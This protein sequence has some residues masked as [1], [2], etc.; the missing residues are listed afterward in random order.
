MAIYNF[1]QQVYSLSLTANVSFNK[2]FAT[3]EALQDYVSNTIKDLL[4]DS[5]TQ[6]VIGNWSVIW[7]PYTWSKNAAKD[8]LK[9]TSSKPYYSD[10]T[11]YLAYNSDTN[12][13]VLAIAG[14][15][16]ISLFD[17]LYEDLYTLKSELWSK[18]VPNTPATNAEISEGTFK[19]MNILLNEINSQYSKSKAGIVDFLTYHMKTAQSGATLA[20]TGHSLGGALSPSLATF[21]KE[22]QSNWDPTGKVTVLSTYPT[23]GPTP[24]NEAFAYHIEDQMGENYHALYNELDLVPHAWE[25]S[26]MLKIPKLYTTCGI[27][28]PSVVKFAVGLFCI[29]TLKNNYQQAKPLTKLPGTCHK[30]NTQLITGIID[31]I[32]PELLQKLELYGLLDVHNFLNFL[33]EAA[34][35]HTTAYD[36]LLDLEKYSNL[37][38]KATGIKDSHEQ[39]T[40]TIADELLKVL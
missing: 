20:V 30:V 11:M 36:S 35:Q 37:F 14:T 23:A 28:A 4:S 24:G 22:I 7:G 32:N 38:G 3:L 31:K 39:I 29:S 18:L 9:S 27:P 17:W 26:M 10:N 12:K 16:E 5:S 19:G 15:N 8:K 13:Y 40:L 34:Y 1:E 2:R 6:V 25:I 33:Y 21:L